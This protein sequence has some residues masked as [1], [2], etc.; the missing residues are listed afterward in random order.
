MIGMHAIPDGV[1]FARRWKWLA[2][3]TESRDFPGGEGSAGVL[4]RFSR[5][6]AR[7]GRHALSGTRC[8]GL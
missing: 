6:A 1:R 5:G 7:H 8:G 4:I 2:I 3:G